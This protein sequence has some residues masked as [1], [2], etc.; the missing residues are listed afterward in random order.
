YYF[1]LV[2]CL[3]FW[4]YLFPLARRLNREYWVNAINTFRIEMQAAELADRAREIAQAKELAEKAS[5]E[6]SEFL[7]T[8]SHELR[9]PLSGMLGAG[10]LVL[11]MPLGDA[12]RDYIDLIRRSGVALLRLIE[13]LLVAS[14]LDRGNLALRRLPF[15]PL[16]LANEVMSLF[17]ASARAAG[18]GLSLEVD[19]DIPECVIGDA[20]RIKQVLMNLVSNAIHYTEQGEVRV[21]LTWHRGKGEPA[22]CFAVIDTGPGIASEVQEQLFYRYS[23][24]HLATQPM[25]SGT[26]LGLAISRDLARAMG[27]EISLESKVG[28][29]T[30]FSFCVPAPPMDAAPAAGLDDASSPA[31][32]P[33]RATAPDEPRVTQALGNSPGAFGL[34]P[35]DFSPLVLLADDD[36]V[37]RKVFGLL[38]T[39]MGCRVISVEDGA[40]ALERCGRGRVDL[41]L[42]DVQMPLL[43]GVQ[44][45]ERLRKTELQR[46]T[47]IIGISANVTEHVRLEATRAGMNDVLQKPIYGEVLRDIIR[48]HCGGSV[49]AVASVT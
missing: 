37:L 10:E 40:A 2:S 15:A 31:A 14:R 34:A 44:V 26:G 46:T 45:A 12:Q 18:L 6:K 3:I 9:T 22:L 19:G 41:I 7:A 20:G 30:T 25:A 24:P 16:H 4:A 48:A 8:V 49:R 5:A 39:K 36:P 17:E 13:D 23:A 28:Q 1:T 43:G 27:G 35:L 21:H 33:D 42:L 38:A 47:P 32:S 29:G 11:Q